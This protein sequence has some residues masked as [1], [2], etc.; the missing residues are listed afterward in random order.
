MVTS[1]KKTN[2]LSV[3]ADKTTNPDPVDAVETTTASTTAASTSPAVSTS[4]AASA[5]A[6][7]TEETTPK[8]STDSDQ[9]GTSADSSGFSDLDAVEL[10]LNRELTW[11]EFN[12]RVLHE[13][14]DDSN[15]LLERL[16]FVGIVSSN[17]DEFFMKRIGGLKQQ[18]GAGILDY[19][20]DGRLPAQ[21]IEECYEKV[22]ELEEQKSE[23]VANLIELLAERDIHIESYDALSDDHKALIRTYYF[24]NIYPLVTPQGVDSAHPFPF[25]S[26]LSLNLLVTLR[27]NDSEEE[28][29][30]RVKVPVGLGIPR[31]LQVPDSHIFV[32]LESVM[33]KNL[34]VLFPKMII[35]ACE[36]FYVTRN[37]N[38]ARDEDE[39]DDLLAII[40][41]EVRHRRFAK[42]VRVVVEQGM[43]LTRRGMLAAEL[44]LDEADVFEKKG[45]LSTRDLLSLCDLEIP[46][47]R[48]TPHYP[49]DH[50]KLVHMPNI[51]HAVR[52][53]GSILLQHPYESFSTS[54]ERLLREASRDPKVR[55]IKMTLYRTSGDTKVIDYLVD[56]AQNGKQVAVVVEL[57]ARFDEAANIRWSSRL[58]EAGIH[59]T[60]GVMDL[61]THCKVIMVVRNDYSGLRRY[62]HIG[63]GNY[64]AGNARLYTDLGLLT[65]DQDIGRDITEL[66]N[67]LTTGFT[68]KRNYRKI[69]PA[70]KLLKRALLDKIQREA[71]LVEQGLDGHIQIKV[72]ALEDQDI[73]R[74]L[75][76]ASQADVKVDLIVRD[77][78]R[79]RPGIPGLSENIRVFSVV[80]R[81]LEH[82]RIYYFQ[83]NDSP[84]YYIGSADTMKR[85]LEHRVEVLTPV[86]DIELQAGLRNIIETL[87]SDDY[88]IWQ[89]NGDGSYTRLEGKNEDGDGSQQALMQHAQERI[90][91]AKRL[92]R[93]KPQ[94][95]RR[96]NIHPQSR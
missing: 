91:D 82:S 44:G 33:A 88:S 22:R 29:R 83:N 32:P 37:A 10:Y 9:P 28:V 58:E 85:N 42:I 15:P 39:A 60:Y 59:V 41:S 1:S 96:R 3:V 38:T 77:S 2:N 68:P 24:E 86:E 90:R 18:V 25:I 6:P 27:H 43:D 55:A 75:Y 80:G 81:F 12:R 70:P 20:V 19:S 74:A 76:R 47:L 89:M 62:V 36:L 87:M 11:L 35:E 26:N 57:K 5:A 93:R 72:N 7:T 78:C 13:A 64:H 95:M 23:L 61:K 45:L 67:Y 56:A 49:I 30:A 65:C 79:L 21:Q 34:D 4:P 40:E 51:F 14:L 48:D 50:P 53:A 69:L 71:D 16:K 17:L 8:T 92:K 66:F 94:G 52:D 54:V 73:V 84:E 31:F 63:T 46:A